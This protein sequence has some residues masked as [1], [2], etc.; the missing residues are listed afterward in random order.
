MQACTSTGDHSSLR[1]RR[2][3]RSQLVPE[4]LMHLDVSRLLDIDL[5]PRGSSSDSFLTASHSAGLADMVNLDW[6]SKVLE[7]TAST[8]NDHLYTKDYRGVI[9]DIAPAD[10]DDLPYISY[11]CPQTISTSGN[12]SKHVVHIGPA[13]DLPEG[14]TMKQL[15]RKSGVKKGKLDTYW[16]TPVLKK[17]LR[18]KVQVR[19]FIEKMQLQG[20]EEAVYKELAK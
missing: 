8:W 3:T 15:V 19:K 17:Q 1:K 4:P 10:I 16:Y 2:F 6:S 13:E 20:D 11:A 5:P 7:N 12:S 18:S 9:Y 14:W